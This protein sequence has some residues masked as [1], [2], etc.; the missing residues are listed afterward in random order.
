MI[1][2]PDER[3]VTS[4]LLGYQAE[5]AG[6]LMTTEFIDLKEHHTAQEALEIVR[7]RA[8]DTETVYN[9]MSRTLNVISQDS[10]VEDLV[11]SDVQ[12]RIG[13]VM[14]ADVH[15]VRTDT[16]QEKVART[17]QRYDFLAVPVVDLEQRLVGIVTV[18]DVI[19]VI[20]QEAT[21]D[22]MCRRCSGR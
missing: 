2:E 11:T 3:R 20:E 15:S 21:R 8:R 13:D 17:I 4:E 7:R 16:D 10:V 6:R 12:G 22:H 1:A 9:F 14:T 5:T 19:D 18:D